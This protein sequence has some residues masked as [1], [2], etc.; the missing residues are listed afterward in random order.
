[1]RAGGELLLDDVGLV[2]EA[3][4]LVCPVGG[5]LSELDHLVEG[6][7]VLS[8]QIGDERTALFDV[9]EFPRVVIQV[10]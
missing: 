8:F 9:F 10:S 4:E 7:S 1:M 2:E 6:V 3:F 5:A